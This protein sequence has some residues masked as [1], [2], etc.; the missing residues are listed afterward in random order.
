M[1]KRDG[2]GITLVGKTLDRKPSHDIDLFD[3]KAEI[4]IAKYE[5]LTPSSSAAKKNPKPVR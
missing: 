2:W 5:R 1:S 3:I 4:A